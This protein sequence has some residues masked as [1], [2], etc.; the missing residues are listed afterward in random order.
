MIGKELLAMFVGKICQI[1]VKDTKITGRIDKIY[2]G[3][4]LITKVTEDENGKPIE[5]MMALSSPSLISI[6]VIEEEV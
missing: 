6:E 4:I 3:A 5:T 2:G 1:V